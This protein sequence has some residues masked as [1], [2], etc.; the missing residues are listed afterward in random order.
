MSAFPN[1]NDQN[2]GNNNNPNKNNLN[3][4][5][6]FVNQARRNELQKRVRA[7]EEEYNR[8]MSQ[9]PEGG[10]GVLGGQ[11]IEN[12]N[13]GYT[14]DE[15]EVLRTMENMDIDYN[16][17]KKLLIIQNEESNLANKTSGGAEQRRRLML[18]KVR[19][20]ER[21]REELREERTRKAKKK[22]E[23]KIQKKKDL[24]RL[25]GLK[26]AEREWQRKE[27]EKQISR[28]HADQR[29][30]ARLKT[31]DRSNSNK[32][33]KKSNMSPHVSQ[34]YNRNDTSNDDM[35][36]NNNFD[37]NYKCSHSKKNSVAK[38]S[39]SGEYWKRR[40]MQLVG[41]N[42]RLKHQNDMLRKDMAV[43]KQQSGHHVDNAHLSN[44]SRHQIF[45]GSEEWHQ[46]IQCDEISREATLQ[47]LCNAAKEAED[48][49]GDFPSISYAIACVK[50]MMNES[51]ANIGTERNDIQNVSLIG[52]ND[53]NN[54]EMESFINVDK[55]ENEDGEDL[56][57]EQKP[58][59]EELRA[60][61]LS[62]FT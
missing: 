61:R 14:P 53:V 16:Q 42:H 31:L 41:E 34:N 57:M 7:D 24:A 38:Q 29:R 36:N 52:M 22:E 28:N 48:G 27:M 43:L 2:G 10:S 58:T 11:M 9:R 60:L 6:V 12:Q 23:D 17:A 21:K 4:G 62:R 25:K 40:A 1:N 8:Y 47:Y 15:M 3:F 44:N 45:I 59:S 56:E 39:S 46:L 5:K 26:N 18:T 54:P 49:N 32:K 35:S 33:L 13:V 55:N 19:E 37:N 30:E 20:R 50:D 51:I